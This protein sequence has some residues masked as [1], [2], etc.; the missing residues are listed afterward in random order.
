[1]KQHIG[2]YDY[3]S[4]KKEATA[5]VKSKDDVVAYEGG[6][7]WYIYSYKEYATNIRKRIFGFQ[8]AK[9]EKMYSVVLKKKV[10]VSNVKM[11][12]RKGR[13]FKVGQYKANGRMYEAWQIM[14]KAKK[15]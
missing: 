2:G 5:S 14:G 1:M 8:E 12:N 15:K 13:L 4:T 6:L 9:M 7:G 10:P 3:Y 11:K